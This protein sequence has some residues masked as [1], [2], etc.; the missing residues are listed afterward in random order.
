MRRVVVTGLGLVSP[1]GNS[2]VESWA[3]AVA[4]K[5]G[6]GPITHFDCR[7]Y[8]TKIAG[9]VRGFDPTKW[10]ESRD[11]KH[12]DSFVHYAI[13]AAEQAIAD[14]GLRAEGEEDAERIGVYIGSGLSGVATIEATYSALLEKGPRKGFSPYFVPKIITNIA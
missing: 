3:S 14:A 2:I 10:I 6:I 5:S 1:L 12:M 4:G 9:E 7:D 13:A 11:A 8:P